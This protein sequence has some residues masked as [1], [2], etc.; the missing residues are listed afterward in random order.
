MKAKE[1]EHKFDIPA[2][3]DVLLASYKSVEGKMEYQN[4]TAKDTLKQWKCSCG[5]IQTYDL[6]R[7]MAWKQ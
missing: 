6:E 5:L 7:I 3:Q 1:H 4:T 2:T